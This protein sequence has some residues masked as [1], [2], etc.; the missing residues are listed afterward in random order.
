MSVLVTA[1]DLVG[2]ACL[3]AES[4]VIAVIIVIIVLVVVVVV[5]ITTRLCPIPVLPELFLSLIHI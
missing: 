5:I 4:H 3:V 1:M 2:G